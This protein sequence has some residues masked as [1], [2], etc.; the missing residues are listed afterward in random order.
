MKYWKNEWKKERKKEV[1]QK[2]KLML[3][4][5]KKISLEK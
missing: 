4:K 3:K 5:G 1:D 2:K